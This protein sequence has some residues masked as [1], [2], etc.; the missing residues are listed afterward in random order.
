MA[1]IDG[2]HALKSSSE[3]SYQ[4]ECRPCENGGIT[5]QTKFFCL[6]CKEYLCQSCETWHKRFRGTKNHRV[7]S[8][9]MI[10]ENVDDPNL[11]T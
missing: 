2:A 5:K 3:E 4:F 9:E 10:P 7:V 8:G 11:L 1:E 6:Q